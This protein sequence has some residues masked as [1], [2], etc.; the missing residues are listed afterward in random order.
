MPTLMSDK[1]LLDLNTFSGLLS[2]GPDALQV[3]FRA[4]IDASGEVELDFD[5]IPLTN[6]TKFIL[7][8]WNR[9]GDGVTHFAL[10]GL[11][12]DS[13]RFDTD[14][15]HFNTLGESSD[16]S[17]TRMTPK[18]RCAKAVFSLNLSQPV[19]SPVLRTRMKGFENFASHHAEC[20][21]GRVAITGQHSFEN[22]NAL[23]G[24]I[25]IEATPLPADPIAWRVEAEKLL[26]HVRDIMSLAASSVL[27]APVM[28]YF[29]G[30][31][32]EITV[33][34]ATVQH[35]SIFRVIHFLAQETIFETAVRSFFHPPIIVN[36]LSFAIE[37]LAMEAIYNEERLINAMTALENLIDSNLEERDTLIQP[38]QAFKKT[39]RVLRK[40][41]RS[42]LE[43]WSAED[44]AEALMELNEKLIDLN[45]RSFLRKL[46]ILAARWDVPLNGI[47]E[48]SLNAAKQARDKV[49]HRGQYYED[50]EEGDAD[51]WTHAAI[52][53]EAAVRFLF[54][55]IG[56]KGRYISYVGGCHDATFPPGEEIRSAL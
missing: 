19:K 40:A 32:L 45:R 43:K 20:A 42:C 39:R 16:A 6:E 8:G 3:R 12:E 1:R 37:W 27:R 2:L 46:Q 54:T 5:P 23:T 13:T 10:S 15:L 21:L 4:G 44:S 52:I 11:A 14:S 50:W 31:R 53:R 25:V 33:T 36:R 34:S 47:S 38:K 26:E 9:E 7:F 56:Y 51:L 48:D 41:I 18:A 29:A 17:G 35:P 55:V 30:D 49:V 24:W 28:E 22:A